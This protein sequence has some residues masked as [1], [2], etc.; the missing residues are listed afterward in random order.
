MHSDLVSFSVGLLYRRI[1]GVL[2]RNEERGFDVA[3]VWISA[4]AVEYLF[5][6]FDVVVVDGVVKGYG[7]HLRHF[8]VRQVVGYSRTVLGT[9][10]VG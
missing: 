2:V 6:Q 1:V 5:V 9:E 4:L 8:F 3:S 10:T 7:D